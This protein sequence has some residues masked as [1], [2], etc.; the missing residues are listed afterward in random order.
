MPTFEYKATTVEG[1][2]LTGQREGNDKDAVIVWLQESGYIPIY[3]EEISEAGKAAASSFSFLSSRQLSNNQILEIT[4]QLSTLVRSKLPLD[5]ALKILQQIAEHKKVKLLIGNLLESVEAGN[6]FSTALE[7]QKE[8]SPF[9]INMIRASEAS[10]NLDSGLEQLYQ[11]MDGVKQMRD[12][13]LSALL[14]PMILLGVAGISILLILT[15]VVPKITELFV[16]TDRA[17]PIPTQVVI[18]L[19]N[20]V[21]DF[22]WLIPIAIVLLIYYLRYLNAD[23]QR[24]RRWHRLFLRLPV[25]RDLVV[26]IETAK[27]TKS[28]GTLVSNGV[29]MQT[30]LP[31]ANATLTNVE[32]SQNI[33]RA[34]EEFKEGKSLFA[35]MK[36]VKHFPT[37][38]L[39]MINVGEETGELE[40]MLTRVADVY[41][42]ETSAAMQRFL[43]LL[44]PIMIIS[45]GLM[46]GGIIVSILMA[47]ISVNDLPL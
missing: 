32:F 1:K 3:A 37:L 39:Q 12:K 28:L 30:A 14:Y 41:Q 20:A 22:W 16:G 5:H 7:A 8:F 15:F 9:Y 36:K 35:I 38:A 47:I 45:L 23:N 29:N 24:K 42:R 25:L 43:S 4:E 31:I 34:V 17:L 11:Y 46:I 40:S 18:S 33:Q 21:I 10:G 2:I 27:F 6:E 13:I 26:K 19:S 44:E